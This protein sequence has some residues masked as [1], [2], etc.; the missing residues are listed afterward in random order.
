MA[1]RPKY[2]AA[3]E[4]TIQALGGLLQEIETVTACTANVYNKLVN[5]NGDRVA[6]VIV[7]TGANDVF[8]GFSSAVSS[9]QGIRLGA[10]GG[11]L[12]LTVS[13]DYTLCTREIG[14]I[15]SAGPNNVYTLEYNRLVGGL[16]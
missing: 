15:C 10:N 4:Y 2:G 6:I 12:T 7:N 13:E 5:G 14:A 9:S 8:V 11:A 3:L 1:T 16:T